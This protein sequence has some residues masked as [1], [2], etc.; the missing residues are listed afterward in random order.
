MAS[1]L[2]AIAARRATSNLTRL[3]S[4][5]HAPSSLIQR[6]TFSASADGHHG[7]QRINIWQDP[8]SPSKWKEEQFVLVSLFGWGLLFTGAYK[9]FTR[10]KK[11][12]DKKLVEAS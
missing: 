8:M 6:R 1:S 12:D 10:G 7:P 11:N 4:S 2:G 3:S 5:P 9:F